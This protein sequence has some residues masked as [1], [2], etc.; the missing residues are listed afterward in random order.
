MTRTGLIVFAI[1]VLVTVVEVLV[2]LVS[3]LLG[4]KKLDKD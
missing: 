1:V 3:D 2:P 4:I